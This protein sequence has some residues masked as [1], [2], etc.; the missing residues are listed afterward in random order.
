MFSHVSV[1]Y[2][3]DIFS[4]SESTIVVTTNTIGVMG[5]GIARQCKDQFPHVFQQYRTACQSGE[6]TVEQ[7][8][9]VQ[10]PDPSPNVLCFATKQDWRNPSQLQWLQNGLEWMVHNQSRLKSVAIPPLGCGYGGLD[11]QL[12]VRPLLIEFLPKFNI[13]VALYLPESYRRS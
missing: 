8:Y 6:H 2:Q 12:Q 10:Q 3:S 1:H 13:P 4:A 11:W 5:A 9:L 7:P